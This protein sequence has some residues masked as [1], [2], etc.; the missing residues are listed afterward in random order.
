MKL[1]E[2]GL[3]KIKVIT[4][5]LKIVRCNPISTLD[6]LKSLEE[7]Q[8]IHTDDPWS[9]RKT[10]YSIELTE[11]ENL[12]T[13]FD[14][15]KRN[16]AIKSQSGQDGTPSKGK[17]FIH[18]NARLC[19]KEITKFLY[20]S[21]LEH[22]DKG[23][24][25]MSYGTNGGKAMCSDNN[26]EIFTE[27]V[28]VDSNSIYLRFQNY[29][30]VIAEQTGNVR[31]LLKYEINYREISEEAYKARKLDKHEGRAVCG[32]SEWKTIDQK[33]SDSLLKENGIEWMKE[34][35]FIS[36]LTP[37]TYYALY[38]TTMIGKKPML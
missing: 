1:L 35:T 14:F 20:D 15:S 7:I 25:D 21:G 5:S 13:L 2:D 30:E 6:F 31:Q 36:P 28:E 4:G 3:G 10:Y 38:V 17:V 12:L 33:P 26:L 18:Y 11:N 37:F 9:D 29:Q 27:T 22:P 23:I 32:A 24:T 19:K 34:E 8:G 16:V